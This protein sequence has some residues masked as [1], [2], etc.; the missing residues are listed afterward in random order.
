RFE[1]DDLVAGVHDCEQR[2][3]HGLGRATGDGYF[4]IGVAI[5][6]VVPRHLGGD[7]LTELASAPGY[8]VLIVV[9][10]DSLFGRFLELARRRKIWKP[11]RQIDAA[12]LFAQAGHG[13]DDRFGEL[14]RLV[15]NQP[16]RPQPRAGSHFFVTSSIRVPCAASGC[17]NETRMWSPSR[18]W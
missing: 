15:G 2:R 13:A 7:R 18:G 16:H 5:Y 9:R 14:L 4:G 11:L 10:V 8:G 6:M 17:R 12:V 1:D 3:N